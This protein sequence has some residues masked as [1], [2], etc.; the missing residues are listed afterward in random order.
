MPGAVPRMWI[1]SE[2]GCELI[3]VQVDRFLRNWRRYHGPTIA[4]PTYDIHT[5]PNFVRDFGEFLEFTKTQ[6]LPT[7]AIDQCEITYINIIQPCDVWEH[8]G[9]LDRVFKG[10]SSDYPKLA[11][12]E[13]LATGWRAQHEVADANGKFVGHLFVELDSAFSVPPGSP[14]SSEPSPIFQLQLTVRGRPLGEGIDGV[15]AF[16]DLGHSIIVNSFVAVTTAEMHAV[17]GRVQ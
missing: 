14:P 9:Q 5:R 3:Q 17:W 15:M 6:R 4:Y 11:G 7:P 12:S 16:M 13:A 8:F 10:W 2:D 1:I